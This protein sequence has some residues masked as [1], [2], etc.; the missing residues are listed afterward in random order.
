M[1]M[2]ASVTGSS[3]ANTARPILPSDKSVLIITT[4][5][6]QSSSSHTTSL[7]DTKEYLS[8]IIRGLY[9]FIEMAALK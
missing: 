3:Y 5:P 8:A 4:C 6:E 7:R 2:M 9:D 1:T